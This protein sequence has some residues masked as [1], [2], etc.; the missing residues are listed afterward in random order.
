M[1]IA[2]DGMLLGR[3]FSGVEGSITNLARALAAAG[4]HDYTLFTRAPFPSS[5]SPLPSPLKGEGVSVVRDARR[6]PRIA[7]ASTGT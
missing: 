3:R 1:R 6:Q 4:K 5:P 2:I 7:S